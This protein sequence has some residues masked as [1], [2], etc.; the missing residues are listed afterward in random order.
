MLTHVRRFSATV[1]FIRPQGH[2]PALECTRSTR[3]LRPCPS[4]SP[5]HE[6]KPHPPPSLHPPGL[7]GP[8]PTE[9]KAQSCPLGLCAQGQINISLD[10][11]FPTMAAARPRPSTVMTKE[12]NTGLGSTLQIVGCHTT[13]KSIPPVL[14]GPPGPGP[15]SPGHLGISWGWSPGPTCAAGN[16]AGARQP[17]G[18]STL[19]QRRKEPGRWL[20]GRLVAPPRVGSQRRL[21]CAAS[22]TLYQETHGENEFGPRDRP[23]GSQLSCLSS[24]KPSLTTPRPHQAR[25]CWLPLHLCCP[26]P[27]HSTP[28]DATG[29]LI[30][31]A[32]G[33]WF[34]EGRN[35]LVFC[36]WISPSLPTPRPKPTVWLAQ[37]KYL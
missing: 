24:R 34:R 26:H 13:G 36:L 18:P 12:R 31:H 14:L 37:E 8:H 25:L 6:L 33:L 2:C 10:P 20:V 30:S 15:S 35:Y 32:T 17:T 5:A 11:Q 16:C 28:M 23:P 29:L 19:A 7:H 1:E 4:P 9:E 3:P 22:S 27:T 21:L